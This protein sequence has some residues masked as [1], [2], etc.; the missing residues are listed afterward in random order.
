MSIKPGMRVGPYDVTAPLGQG[1]MGVVFRARD[2]RLQRDVALKVL[3][4]HF[5]GDADR[6]SRFQRE[7]QVLASLNHPNI[8]QIYG[9]EQAGVSNC[10]VME[11]VEGETLADRLKRGPLPLDDATQIAKQIVEALEAAHER[12]IV[13]RDL[14]PANIKL[15]PDGKVKVLDFGLAKAFAEGGADSSLSHSPTKVSGSIA[16]VVMGTAAYMSPEQAR[17][18][19]VDARTDIWAFGCVLFEMLTARQTFAGETATDVIARI[20]EGQ[21]QWDRLPAETPIPIRLLLEAAL[22]KDAKQRLQHIGGSRVFLNRS[23]TS[24]DLPRPAV[25]HSAGTRRVWPASAALAIVLVAAIVPTVLYFLRSPAD[26]MEMRF[27]ISAPALGSRGLSIAVS[28]DGRLIAYIAASEGKMAIWIRPIGSL[29]ARVLAGTENADQVFWSPDGRNLGFTADGKLK[30]VDVSGG[31]P[32][33]LGQ[34]G[35]IGGGAWSRAGDIIFTGASSIA[36]G[37]SRIAAGGG[38]IEQITTPDA[39]RAEVG[40]IGAQFLPDGRH[41]TYHA[42]S[43]GSPPKFTTY[44]G[45]LDSKEPPRLLMTAD[46]TAAPPPA[47]MPTYVEPGY[48]MFAR[49]GTLMA[50]PFDVRRFEFTG[51]PAA[52]AE[53]VLGFAASDNGVLIY[54]KAVGAGLQQLQWIDRAGAAKGN[55][56]P[57]ADYWQGLELS[58]DGRRVA[59]SMLTAG[60]IEVW[61]LDLERGVPNRLTFEP[62]FDN[63]PLWESDGSRLVWGT[64]RDGGAVTNKFYRKSSSGVGTEEKLYAGSPDEATYSGDLSLDGRH[65]VFLHNSVARFVHAIWYLPLSGDRK[66]VTYLDTAFSNIQPQLSPDGRW[67]AYATNESGTYQI[68]VRTFPDPNGGRW[69]VT[70]N[71]GIE[72][73]WRRD[74]REL[75]YIGPDGKLMAVPI[76]AGNVF[77]TEAAIPLFQTPFT[78]LAGIPYPI[79]YDVSADG[80]RF[81]MTVPADNAL[82]A[83][84]IVAIV[85][86]TAALRKQ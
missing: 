22:N 12:G 26:A 57:P 42:F 70:A 79:R 25:A 52:V 10:I 76:S 80:Q 75:Y 61:V 14:K 48:M 28:P 78:Q 63:G 56:G 5:A 16:G 83:T 23:S 21:P 39:S 43:P 31:S 40:H 62:G 38:N 64:S 50:Q 37:I 7:A 58:P 45:S 73:R 27:E 9:L 65:L 82:S 66:P 32:T 34:S 47:G 30:R 51:E 67:L 54:Q 60:D 77:Q 59:F 1:G 81:L 4:D 44:I 69:Q 72:P 6:L 29:T 49:A 11:L 13:H 17:G 33:I 19:V 84:P 18:K 86:W 36:A 2:N 71:G 8:A 24:L 55:V 35:P 41:F 20:L 74:G 3:P 15:T 53:G 68:V 46:A 85:N